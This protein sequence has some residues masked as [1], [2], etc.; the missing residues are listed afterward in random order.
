MIDLLNKNGKFYK[1]NLHCH[2]TFS[3]GKM[4]P[5]QVKNHY[6]KHGYSIVAFTD[7]NK[8]NDHSHLN[9]SDFLAINGIETDSA[10]R[11]NGVCERK[12]TCHLNFYPRDYKTA[13][14][15]PKPNNYNVEELNK[16]VL[17][18]K[19]N[20]WLCTLNHTA[21]SLMPTQDILAFDNLVGFEVYNHGCQVLYN[22]GD[23]QTDYAMYLASG[24]RAFAVAG[25]DNHHGYADEENSIMAD[26]DD[27]LGGFIYISMPKLTHSAF[28][29]A[30]ENGRFY[31][32]TGPEIYD[33]YID[34]DANELVI[35]CSP[36]K[37]VMVK[38]FK[39]ASALA[40]H[41]NKDD[42]TTLRMPLDYIKNDSK[43]FFRVELLTTD[44][45]RAYTQPYYFN[46]K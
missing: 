7:H 30:F 42:I 18:M 34:E 31:A 16:Y 15:L 26:G 13:V 17:D 8:F 21:W 33:L 2:T 27:T 35:N 24:K 25:D 5:E 9:D 22:N 19:N 4:T 37:S 6:K 1:A 3:D 10:L 20:G 28:I 36:V 38:C 11:E 41:H 39:F 45:K 32:S 40:V 29:D 43:Y 12:V 46:E 44:G 23:S 14:V